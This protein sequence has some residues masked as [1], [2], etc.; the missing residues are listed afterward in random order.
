[1]STNEDGM[2]SADSCG[3]ST[4]HPRALVAQGAHCR[5]LLRHCFAIMGGGR[6]AGA[7]QSMSHSCF[8]TPL[9]HNPASVGRHT[10]AHAHARSNVAAWLGTPLPPKVAVQLYAQL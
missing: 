6:K 5:E 4:S 3:A 8:C 2:Q 1:M 9:N 7:P 10:P